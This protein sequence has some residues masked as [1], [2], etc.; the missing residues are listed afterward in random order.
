MEIGYLPLLLVRQNFNILRN[1]SNT[2]RLVRLFPALNDFL[3]Y[4]QRIYFD[5]NFPPTMW[6]VFERNMDNSVFKRNMDNRSN[7]FVESK[8]IDQD[9]TFPSFSSANVDE[10]AI[11]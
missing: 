1:A 11:K 3:V 7:N 4:V 6:N 9:D 8:F 10:N 5:G 2:R